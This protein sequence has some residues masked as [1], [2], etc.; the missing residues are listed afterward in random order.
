MENVGFKESSVMRCNE[1]N[2]YRNREEQMST[3][4]STF[5][6]TA[7]YLNS[8]SNF[9]TFNDILQLQLPILRR[10]DNH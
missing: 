6:A 8:A 3:P 2:E 4:V 10:C 9:V 1:A 5:I 7:N